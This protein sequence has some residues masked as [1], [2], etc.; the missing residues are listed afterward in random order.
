MI[1]D[2]NKALVDFQRNEPASEGAVRGVEHRIGVTFPDGY[3]SFLLASNG[4]EGP[5]GEN[6]YA[7]LWKIEQLQELTYSYEVEK[8]A[9][10]LLLIGSNGGGE[11]FALDFEKSPTEFV[12]M[13]FVGM[14]R[15][16]MQ[17]LGITFDDFIEA[18]ARS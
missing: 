11:A 9:S 14:D 6:G 10:G 1:M 13:P 15:S 8:Y 4:G 5:V 18:L 17:P 7:M 12:S 3:R 2:L 16:V